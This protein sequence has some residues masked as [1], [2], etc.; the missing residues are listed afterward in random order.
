MLD[1]AYRHIH[2]AVPSARILL[3]GLL[4]GDQRWISAMLA[5]PGVSAIRKFDVAN[6]HVRTKAKHMSWVVK[7]WRAFFAARGFKGQ[8]WITEHGYPGSRLFQ[9]DP[10]FR[11]GEGAQAAF[12]SRSLPRLR[13][14]GASQVFV[15]LRDSWP[16]EFIGEFASEGV[17]SIGERAPYS[18]RRKPSF[19]RIASLNDRW[20][21]GERLIALRRKHV[22]AARRARKAGK[23]SKAR[24]HSKIARS[25]AKRLK[26]LGEF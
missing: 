1:S 12:L 10:A 22:R 15:T 18:V 9:Y 20:R 5:T 25:Y 16:T 6:V 24:R 17:V 23:R 7:R 26:K 2:A 19:A 13:K 8:L 11:G 3:G 14:S 21:K 4:Y